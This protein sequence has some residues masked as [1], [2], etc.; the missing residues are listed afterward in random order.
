MSKRGKALSYFYDT[1]AWIPKNVTF[2]NRAAYDRLDGRKRAESM[3]KVAAAAEARGWL[4]SQEKT[5]SYAQQLAAHGMKVSPPSAA[6][7][8]G[9]RDIGERLTREWITRA[10]SD[11]QTIIDAYRKPAT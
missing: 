6:L 11:G 2:V 7:K 1:Q 10:G 5:K 9:L 4:W 8:T 3:L